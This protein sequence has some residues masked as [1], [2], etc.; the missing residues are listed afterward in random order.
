M[1]RLA[2]SLRALTGSLLA[3]AL[4]TGCVP[5]LESGT[6]SAT[7]SRP[8]AGVEAVDTRYARDATLRVRNVS[9][10][11]VGLGSGFAVSDRILV[12]NKHVV[13]GAYYLELSTWDGRDVEV[14]VQGVGYANDLAVVV[15]A[16]PLPQAVRLAARPRPGATVHAVGYPGGQEWTISS[17]QVVDIVP[18]DLFEEDGDVVR[19]TADIIPGNSGG[20]LFDDF[21][22]VVAVVFAIERVTGYGLAIPIDVLSRLIETSGFVQ[23][24][25]GC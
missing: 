6:G 2:P 14:A 3:V 11:G 17:G 7:G 8:A 22:N 20:P 15:T 4:V 21:G 10:G 24:P 13:D 1:T 16:E 5:Q 19:F 12:T 18:G 25:I 23:P 9:C